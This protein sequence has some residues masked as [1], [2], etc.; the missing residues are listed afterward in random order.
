MKCQFGLVVT[1]LGTW[2]KLPYVSTEMGNCSHNFTSTPVPSRYRTSHVY[3]VQLS[4]AIPPQ[5]FTVSTSDAHGH[6]K[7]ETASL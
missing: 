7:E 1:T 3:P 4:L 2:T 5:I 6:H